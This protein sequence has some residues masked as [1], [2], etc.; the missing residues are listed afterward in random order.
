TDAVDVDG[1]DTTT[2][3]A[4]S[5]PQIGEAPQNRPSTVTLNDI[6]LLRPY[7]SYGHVTTRAGQQLCVS[8]VLKAVWIS[9]GLTD[10]R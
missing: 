2:C 6:L 3:S 4:L 10:D 1:D 8:F 7:C 9:S 5:T